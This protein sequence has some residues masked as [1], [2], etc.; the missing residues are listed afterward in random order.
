MKIALISTSNL[1]NINGYFNNVRTR[2]RHLNNYEGVELDVYLVRLKHDWLLR[3]LLRRKKQKESDYELID[4]IRYNNLWIQYTLIDVILT[5]ILGL[6]KIICRRKLEKLANQF[7]KFEILLAHSFEG[8]Y[9]AYC[10]K[11]KYGIP[12]ICGWHGSDLNITPF[13]SKKIYLLHK[14]L[15]HHAD[16]NLFVSKKLLEKSNE[17]IGGTN[18]GVSY[19][20]I[21]PEFF[22]MSPTTI[23]QLKNKFHLSK[24]FTVGFVGCLREIKNVLVLP[25]IFKKLQDRIENINFVIVGEGQLRDKLINKMRDTAVNNVSFL[26][27]VDPSNMPKIM[28]CLDILVLPS[29]NEGLPLVTIEAIACGVPVVGSD[30]GGIPEAIGKKNVFPLNTEFVDKISDRIFTN[31]LDNEPAPI[32]PNYFSWVKTIDNLVQMCKEIVKTG[33]KE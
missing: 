19:S 7:S 11:Q 16:F 30:V 1:E 25:A 13:R 14:L 23:S 6:R 27:K 31:L 24:G 8:K 9:I 3:L 10:T 26:G 21:S 20:G 4:G 17:I 29:L 18:K 5:Y 33:N 2:V 28:N 15:I 22:R 32:L 12:F